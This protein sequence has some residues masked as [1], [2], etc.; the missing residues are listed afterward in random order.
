MASSLR[1]FPSSMVAG[2]VSNIILPLCP[3]QYALH[4]N[5]ALPISP[6]HESFHLVFCLHLRVFPGT[7]ASNILLS[8]CPSSL[9]LT[10]PYHFSLFSVI[11]F[12]TDSTCTH[13]LCLLVLILSVY[14]YS[15][16]LSTCTDP[17][18]LLVLILSDVRF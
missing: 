9:L 8:T 11:F 10:C 15:S 12:V 14:L 18:C 13:P 16:S 3:V 17:L 6:L 1:F 2:M 5:D 7:G 4:F